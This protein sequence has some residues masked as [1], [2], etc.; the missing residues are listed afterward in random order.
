MGRREGAPN[1]SAIGA[2]LRCRCPA[3]GEGRLFDGFLTVARRCPACGLDFTGLDT[4]D[5]PAVFVI[6]VGGLIVVAGA[7]IVEVTITP[8]YWVHA[9]IWLPA[10]LLVTLGLLRPFKATLVALHYRHLPP[11]DSDRD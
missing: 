3:C 2:G 1:V 4:G 11:Q 6:L 10:I 9:A 8:P 7:L 5:G